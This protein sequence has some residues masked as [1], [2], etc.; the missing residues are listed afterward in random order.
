MAISMVKAPKTKRP[1]PPR[2]RPV[3]VLP[4]S[5][6]WTPPT[7]KRWV[8]K[9]EVLARAGNPPPNYVTVWRWMRDGKFPLPYIVGAGG[10]S[11]WLESEL[12]EWQANLPK[13]VYRSREVA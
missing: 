13:R 9:E 2:Q 12:D 4:P 3:K 10:K 5:P 11:L 8:T 1:N 7:G 6:E